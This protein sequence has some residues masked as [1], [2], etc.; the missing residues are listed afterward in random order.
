MSLA[1]LMLTPN[2]GII[3]LSK[4]SSSW[5]LDD[6][7]NVPSPFS[8]IF[9]FLQHSQQH[10]IK[11]P[12][13]T[14]NEIRVCVCV[15][16]CVC[17]GVWVCACVFFSDVGFGLFPP[18]SKKNYEHLLV[19]HLGTKSPAISWYTRIS[20]LILKTTS[21][22]QELEARNARG[23]EDSLNTKKNTHTHF[24]W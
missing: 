1:L 5:L 8:W 2:A 14:M 21:P 4:L 13:P 17:V 24:Q 9:C 16:V 6:R 19:Q 11:L 23:H 3:P 22:R 18:L 10:F 12:F 15:C 7:D 20:R